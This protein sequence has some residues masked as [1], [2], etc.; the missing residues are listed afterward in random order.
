MKLAVTIPQDAIEAF[1]RRHHLTQLAFFGSVLTDRFGPDSDIDVLFEYHTD[2]VPTLFDV[3]AMEAELSEILGRKADMRTAR[4]LSR[5]SRDEVV[6]EA[7]IQYPAS[8]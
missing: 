6:R 8:F 2:H 5:H 1:C 4:D 7:L 3:A